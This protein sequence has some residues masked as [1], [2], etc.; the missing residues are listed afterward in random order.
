[1]MKTVGEKNSNCLKANGERADDTKSV[2]LLVADLRC[3]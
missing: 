3:I 2:P 1:M